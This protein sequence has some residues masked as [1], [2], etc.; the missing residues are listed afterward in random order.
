[1][2]SRD[3][4]IELKKRMEAGCSQSREKL[5]DSCIPLVISIAKKFRI[6]NKHVDMDDLVQEGNIALINA[7]DSWDSRSHITTVVNRYVTNALIDLTKEKSYH[8]NMPCATNKNLS[9][10]IMKVRKHNG[11]PEEISEKT[12]LNPRRVRL[13]LEIL[14]SR[15]KHWQP[16]LRCHRPL[17]AKDNGQPYCLAD[18]ISITRKIVDND[19]ARIFLHWIGY[20]NKNN[21]AELTARD[22]GINKKEVIETVKIV[23]RKIKDAQVLHQ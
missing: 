12:K 11:T 6:N 16:N 1:M 14:S 7:V 9:R 8:I 22:L 18:L 13:I 20:I 3:E 10:D 4:Q 19:Q 21:K 2:I 17:S 15:R 23:K 5:I